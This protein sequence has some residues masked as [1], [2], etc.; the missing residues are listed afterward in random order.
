MKVRLYRK[1]NWCLASRC[2]WTVRHLSEQES[3]YNEQVSQ[4]RYRIMV[5]HCK[6]SRRCCAASRKTVK[7]TS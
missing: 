6:E 5:A 7:I 4:T 3:L 1:L 2:G